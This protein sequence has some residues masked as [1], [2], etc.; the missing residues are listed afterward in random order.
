MSGKGLEHHQSSEDGARANYFTDWMA[1]VGGRALLPHEYTHSW[2]GKFRR[3]ADLWTPN[4]N[5]P[6]QNDLL[7]VYEGL[8][9]YYGN[10]LT[11]RSGLR[12]LE[13]A[14]DLIAQTAA[15]FEISPGRTW[16]P[17]F[18]K[19]SAVANVSTRYVISAMATVTFTTVSITQDLLLYG[20]FKRQVVT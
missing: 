5:V 3:P 10:V 19:S 15:G 9:D 8:T 1:G 7:W 11:A 4:F 16:R 12:T 14:R 20:G 13:Q 17:L 18:S 2:N 6:M